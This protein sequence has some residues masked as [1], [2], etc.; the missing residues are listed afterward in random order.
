MNFKKIICITMM[1]ALLLAMLSGCYIDMPVDTDDQTKKNP[2]V[3]NN[4]PEGSREINDD[5]IAPDQ[6]K[7]NSEVT[8]N[9]PES[10]QKI[11]ANPIAP[12]Q[13]LDLNVYS[14]EAKAGQTVEIPVVLSNTTGMVS[15]R[16]T[17][18]YDSTVLSLTE[19]RDGGI[20]GSSGSSPDLSKVPYI[21]SW[22][23][24]TA[25]SNFTETGT[26][27]TLVF[28]VNEKASVGTYAIELSYDEN[29]YDIMDVDLKSVS[30]SI[31]NGAIIVK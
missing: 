1:L 24:D 22:E 19:V 7:E 16:L 8:S 3:T 29:A 31:A 18:N 2:D 4:E 30:I 5:S 13:M 6:T 15:V 12:E 14:R 28:Q 11:N 20:M 27:V 23:N 17:L 10:S 21:L 25:T 9:E 26:L